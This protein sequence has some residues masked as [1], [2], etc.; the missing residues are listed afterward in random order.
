MGAL[1]ANTVSR[2]ILEKIANYGEK[3]LRNYFSIAEFLYG[4]AVR[5]TATFQFLGVGDFLLFQRKPSE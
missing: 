5:T 3:R 2:V 1:A 4:N